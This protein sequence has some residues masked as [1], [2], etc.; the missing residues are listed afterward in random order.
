VTNF[1]DFSG[2]DI[3]DLVFVYSIS[4]MKCHDFTVSLD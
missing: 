2:V 1:Q 4:G 3:D